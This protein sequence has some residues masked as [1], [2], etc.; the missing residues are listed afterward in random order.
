MAKMDENPYRSP[1]ECEALKPPDRQP[2]AGSWVAF[3][4]IGTMLLFTAAA[5]LTRFWITSAAFDEALGAF[6]AIISAVCL[7]YAIRLRQRGMTARQRVRRPPFFVAPLCLRYSV[8]M[9]ENQSPAGQD[10]SKSGF[11]AK[12]FSWLIGQP[13]GK[14]NA[15]C[16]FCR[17]SYKDVGPLVEGPDSA[18]ICRECVRL[19]N[20]IL[21]QEEQRRAGIGNGSNS[22][23]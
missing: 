12:H 20:A 7:C 22:P 3:G 1:A 23:A 11:F 9:D 6:S 8:G 16:S 19:C 4:F 13:L 2:T 14:K 17:K 18:F 5:E 15:Y 10:P 21:D